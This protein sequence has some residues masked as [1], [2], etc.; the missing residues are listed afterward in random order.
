MP[1]VP[2]AKDHLPIAINHNPRRQRM[3]RVDQPALFAWDSTIRSGF[4]SCNGVLRG[5]PTAFENVLTIYSQLGMGELLMLPDGLTDT[6]FF[7]LDNLS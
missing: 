3:G 6:T 2:A 1:V 4:D 7:L 5:S